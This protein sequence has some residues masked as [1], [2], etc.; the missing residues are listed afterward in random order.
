MALGPDNLAYVIYT[1]GSTGRPKGVMVSHGGLRNYLS[2]ASA[3]YA[4]SAGRGALVHSPLAFDLTVTSLLLPLVTGETVELLPEGEVDQVAARLSEG[5]EPGLL[6]LTPAHVR[7]LS[8]LLAQERGSHWARMLVIGGEALHAEELQGLREQS[9]QTWIVN[10]YGPTETVVG[11]CVH[12]VRAGELR[13]DR[14]RSAGRSR[15][16][17]SMSSTVT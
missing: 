11:C 8:Q 15:T 5:A 9:P 12:A 16:R 2:W 1:S 10:E 4:E 6:K 3:A 13:P 17:G 7:V 14:F